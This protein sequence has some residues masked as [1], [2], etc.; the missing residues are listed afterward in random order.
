V[1]PF[2]VAS[3]L[4]AVLAQRLVRKLCPECKQGRHI[5]PAEL[6]LLGAGN[7]KPFTIC[8]PVGCPA[9]A[10]TGYQSRTGVYELLVVDEALRSMIHDG[11]SEGQLRN[12]ARDRGMIPLREDGVRWLRDGTT[13]LEELIRVTRD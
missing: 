4:S 2:L 1:E 12:H 6:E 13:S 9:C 5:T 10:H 7:V 8:S 3:S 11:T